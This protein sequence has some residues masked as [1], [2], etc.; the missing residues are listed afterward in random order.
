MTR[1]LKIFPKTVG[2]CVKCGTPTNGLY[3]ID[4]LEY[5]AEHQEKELEKPANEQLDL[6]RKKFFRLVSKTND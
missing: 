4:G 1:L 2:V 5:C 6:I 3:Q